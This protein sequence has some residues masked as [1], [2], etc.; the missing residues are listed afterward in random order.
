[1]IKSIYPVLMTEK[2]EESCLFYKNYFG[3]TEAFMSDWYVSLSH[4]DGHELA[5]IEAGHDT[6]PE[7]GRAIIQGMILNI[8]VENAAQMYAEITKKAE[9]IV[10]MPLRDEAYGQRHFI[11][12]D[13]NNII[14]DIIEAI[15]PSKEF[16]ENYNVGEIPS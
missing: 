6:I 15:P 16:Q 7:S 11:M 13:P 2:L 12:Q 5:F 9:G 8:E 1:M 14:V 4:P 10:I 3:F